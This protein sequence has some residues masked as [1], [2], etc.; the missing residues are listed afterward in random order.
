MTNSKLVVATIAALSLTASN[1]FAQDEGGDEEGGVEAT[2][3]VETGDGTVEGEG[4]VAV[5]PPEGG[6]D[7][8]A[9]APMGMTVPKGKIDVTVVVG[10][11]LGESAIAK[12][13]SILPDIFYGVGP[14]LDVGLAH[15]NHALTGFWADGL[16][17][18]LCLSGED[19][20]CGKVYNGPV[21]L[22]AHFGLSDGSVSLAADGGVVIASLSDPMQLGVK[23]GVDGMKMSGKLAIGFKPN[24]YIGL[25]ERDSGNKE[26]L[27]V[28]VDVMYMASDKLGVGVQTGITGPLDGFGDFY[29]IPVSIGAMFKANDNLSVGGSFNL[30]RVAG[31]EGPGA[32]DIRT[33]SLFVDWHN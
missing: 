15:S 8:E 29:S 20:G 11:N 33:L 7:M 27:N 9:A 28:P 31:F 18:G 1:A 24:I 30:L 10:L 16:G 4:A 21:G 12:P 22:L 26:T 5:T 14:K 3:S 19:N 23:L 13:I 2:G 25:T 6:E 32:A 17:G